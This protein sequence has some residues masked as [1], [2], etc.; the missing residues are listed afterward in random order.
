MA[1]NNKNINICWVDVFMAHCKSLNLFFLRLL[2]TN[3]KYI[4]KKQTVINS[5]NPEVS[6]ILKEV[7][8]VPLLC[9]PKR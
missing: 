8:H 9:V 2:N 1:K 4:K 7:T 6:N 5:V 3:Y